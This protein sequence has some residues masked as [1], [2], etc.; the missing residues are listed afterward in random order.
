MS[1][2]KSL[3][4]TVAPHQIDD[5]P[6]SSTVRALLSAV[7]SNRNAPPIQTFTVLVRGVDQGFG[8]REAFL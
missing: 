3:T 2:W 7:K 8:G 4:F 5:I 6:G 1:R